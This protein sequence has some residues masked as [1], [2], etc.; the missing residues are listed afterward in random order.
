M[1]SAP[2]LLISDHR[3]EGLLEALEPLGQRGFR[4]SLARQARDTLR[5]L[6][7]SRPDI[8]VLDPLVPGGRAELEAIR[9]HEPSADPI[10]VLLVAA[11]LDP[12]PAAQ[13]L[14]FLL[15]GPCDLI[16][17]GAPLEE[18]SLRIE[19]LLARGRHARETEE[20][21][22]RALHDDRTDLLRP[23]AFQQRLTEHFSAAQRHHFDLALV[24][25]DLDDFG[26]VNK[27]FD[28]TVGDLLITKVGEVI[29]QTLRTEDV[30][31]RI[32][33]DEFAALLPYTGRVDAAHVVRRLRDA[34]ATL[35]GTIS[36]QAGSVEISAS[37]GFETFDGTDLDTVETLRLH[38]ELALREAKRSGGH[39]AVYYRSLGPR[40]SGGESPA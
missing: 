15:P 5:E 39:R 12:R 3:G 9:R 14:E 1:S 28:H 7:R 13:A 20:L 23:H 40:A 37:L 11:P 35:S 36:G 27:R 6:D 26:G 24:L 2:N 34:I 30:A 10:P 22:H 16:Y 19:G 25:I 29:R 31:G 8:L 21:R 38:T 17:R 18:F 33:G 32:G 4:L